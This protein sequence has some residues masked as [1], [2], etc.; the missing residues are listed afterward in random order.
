MKWRWKMPEM[1]SGLYNYKAIVRSV[2]DGDTCKVD[3][4][5]G[6]HTWIH[7]ETIRLFRINAPEI[8]GP[9][10]PAGLLSRDFLQQQIEGK[11]VMIHT[12]KDEKG[13]Y[14]RYLGDIW[15]KDDA[16]TWIN[17]ND[18]LVQKGFAVYKNY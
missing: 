11:E 12:E 15:F 17:I 18:L 5:L 14:G 7:D 13:K 16:G 2:Y 9:E 1:D 8:R 10:R 4:D 6:L 3:I